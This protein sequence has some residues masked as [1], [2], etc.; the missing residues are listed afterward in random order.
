MRISWNQ[1]SPQACGF[2]RSGTWGTIL[3]LGALLC[4]L[5]AAT[6]LRA[7]E[8][9]IEGQ[10]VAEIRIV[11]DTGKPVPGPATP[12]PLEIGKPF[13]FGMERES[14]R[15]LYRTGDFADIRVTEAPAAPATHGVRAAC[16]EQ[17]SIY[18]S[19][20]RVEGLKEPPHDAAALATMRLTFGEPFRESS[21]REAIDR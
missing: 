21:L 20:T 18:T 14:L 3:S 11:D 5:L 8:A 13:D 4:S 9:Q 10:N 16:T 17:R 15:V 7:Q 1:L 6:S 19:V 12:L 2:Q